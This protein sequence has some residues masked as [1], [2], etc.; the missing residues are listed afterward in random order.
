MNQEQRLKD[1]LTFLSE[2]RSIHIEQ[3][4]DRYQIS[5]D[6]A[7]RDLVRLQESGAIIRTHGGAML[8]TSAPFIQQYEDRL[9]QSAVKQK[10]GA[11]AASLIADRESLFMDASTTVQAAAEALSVS[12]TTI[13]TNSID[14]AAILGKKGQAKIHL[15]GGEYDSFNRN[16]TGAQTIEMVSRYQVQTLLLGA[17]SLSDEGI[18]SPIS[19]EAALKR[20]M[21]RR[22]NRV[23]VLAD[24]EKF[25]KSFVHHVAQW[26]D[27]DVLITDQQPPDAALQSLK[28]SQVEVIIAG[29]E[30]NT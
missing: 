3:I 6:S 12:H 16:V 25:H 1:I 14:I 8:A 27:I 10:I 22:A 20:E 23:I 4:C 15:L 28:E 18:S 9:E 24:H 30:N 17:C 2:H 21:V 26:Q 11:A 19:G 29:G 5:R 7:R 13:I